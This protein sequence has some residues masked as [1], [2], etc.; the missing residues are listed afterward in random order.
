MLESQRDCQTCSSSPYHLYRAQ[1]I[2]SLF[3]T[4]PEVIK[5]SCSEC[6][7]FNR[8]IFHI[9][10]GDRVPIPLTLTTM[11]HITFSYYQG[12]NNVSVKLTASSQPLHDVT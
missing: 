1:D 2:T 7:L 3:Q 11:G 10:T 9:V 12:Y 6:K 5:A 8:E 4:K